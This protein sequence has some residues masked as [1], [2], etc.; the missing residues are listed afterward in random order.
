MPNV[1]CSPVPSS[2]FVQ[3]RKNVFSAPA[4]PPLRPPVKSSA[5]LLHK[6]HM[7]TTRVRSIAAAAR[8]STLLLPLDAVSGADSVTLSPINLPWASL[9]CTN[10]AYPSIDVVDDQ[11]LIG[12]KAPC[13]LIVNHQAISGIHCRIYRKGDKAEGGNAAFQPPL[14]PSLLSKSIEEEKEGGCDG[15]G[16]GDE[17]AEEEDEKVADV[18]AVIDDK[19]KRKSKI[20]VS[21]MLSFFPSSSSSSSATPPTHP[22][23][24]SSLSL[25]ADS[26]DEVVWKGTKTSTMTQQ[27][28]DSSRPQEIWLEDLSTNGTFLGG[29]A[30]ATKVGHSNKVPLHNGSVFTLLVPSASSHE[31]I[32][33]SLRVNGESP[34]GVDDDAPTDTVTIVFTDIES[35]TNLWEACPTGMQ[36]ALEEHDRV[37]RTLLARFRGYEVKTEGDAFMVAFFTVLDAVKWCLAVQEA[38]LRM[39]W[40]DALLT[41]PSA[42]REF[43]D[44]NG[45]RVLEGSDAQMLF[46]GLRVRMGLHVGQPSCRR[47][48]TTKRMD[49]YGKM[50][51]LAARVSDAGHGG[52]IVCTSEVCQIVQEEVQ[53]EKE[54]AEQEWVEER[55]DA[56]DEDDNADNEDA[57]TPSPSDNLQVHPPHHRLDSIT[58]PTSQHGTGT[59]AAFEEALLHPPSTPPP[60]AS[61]PRRAPMSPDRYARISCQLHKKPST[62]D[63]T[64]DHLTD[65]ASVT[66]LDCGSVM[67]KG[68]AGP[69]RI[70][71]VSS[72]SLIGRKWE[73]ALRA[74]GVKEAGGTV[75][76]ESAPLAPPG[77]PLTL[78]LY[79]KHSIPL[80]IRRNILR[81]RRQ[82]K[83]ESLATEVEDNTVTPPIAVSKEAQVDVAVGAGGLSA[84]RGSLTGTKGA[85]KGAEAAKKGQRGSVRFSADPVEHALDAIAALVKAEEKRMSQ[86]T[87]QPQAVAEKT[88]APMPKEEEK[89]DTFDLA[90][91]QVPV[92]VE[93]SPTAAKAKETGKVEAVIITAP[94]AASSLPPS[95]AATSSI[96]PVRGSGSTA[97]AASILQ[98]R[99]A[100]ASLVGRFDSPSP[101]PQAAGPQ[102][103]ATV[104]KADP[105]IASS[106]A[107]PPQSIT[108]PAPAPTASSAPHSP[109][110]SASAKVFTPST[111]SVMDVV[112]LGNTNL[113][114]SLSTPPSPTPSNTN[115]TLAAR[116]RSPR[117]LKASHHRHHRSISSNAELLPNAHSPSA[118]HSAKGGSHQQRRN[119]RS[120]GEA[121]RMAE[122]YSA[123]FD[124]EARQGK[125]NRGGQ[126]TVRQ[127]MAASQQQRFHQP[128][129]YAT[130]TSSSVPAEEYGGVA[131]GMGGLGGDGLAAVE[132]LYA[133][134]AAIRAQMIA[135]QQAHAYN[136]QLLYQQQQQLQAQYM[137]LQQ[138]ATGQLPRQGDMA[139]EHASLPPQSSS[140][141]PYFFPPAQTPSFGLSPAVSSAVPYSYS[142]PA[143][144]QWNGWF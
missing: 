22:S 130:L 140:P 51:N 13:G 90:K 87:T 2:S 134:Q 12:R 6:P 41:L 102:H 96:A 98:T 54:K 111:L 73:P 36:T 28:L 142:F 30:S 132:A 97:L 72:A 35:S 112:P 19:N 113:A 107:I 74:K 114:H 81:S 92:I 10:P 136:L 124:A 122:L 129:K 133:Q 43:V 63:H 116:S 104:P 49:Y 3:S 68:I 99:S 89:D 50:V 131:G 14:S 59:K 86:P 137:F 139:Q 118:R 7:K 11:I 109:A 37:L 69:T 26:I 105:V 16:E 31:R 91:A 117:A 84:A 141:S 120:R 108:A 80:Q 64:L 75:V 128:R 8:G 66:F 78:T 1:S 45:G 62:L 138:Q 56:D 106:A 83:K 76:G 42:R 93:A 121:D 24:S 25:S 126:T 4:P 27:R 88:A 101:Q 103:K 15:D 67:L 65:L 29:D 55:E 47:N 48:P 34:V 18:D 53:R 110:L 127:G 39:K 123:A 115:V 71:Q 125:G 9:L 17:D 143:G 61:S 77:V 60:S 70:H 85:L 58:P 82:L 23:G 94:T 57:T 20:K 52:Q 21:E 44:S 40:D 79:N 135:Q 95:P 32:S 33:Y 46:N 119:N 100:V 5:A 38:F 144:S